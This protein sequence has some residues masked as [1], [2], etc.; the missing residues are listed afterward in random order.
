[1]LRGSSSVWLTT[2][3]RW[4]LSIVS[5]E[6][7]S[8]PL[9]LVASGQLV[10]DRYRVIERIG[11]G[12]LSVVYRGEDTRLPRDIC[13]KVL[14]RLRRRDESARVARATYEHFIQE[15]YALSRLTHPNTLRIFDF[16]YLEGSPEE[17]WGMPL[18][19]SEYMN[20]GTLGQL[21]GREGPLGLG[22]M[23]DI[24][25]GLAE[26]LI[27][28]HG[29]GI[30]HRDLKPPNILFGRVGRRR[31]AKLAD[32]GI[33]EVVSQL[34]VTS[35]EDARRLVM[36][37]LN[38][39]SPEQLRG[40]P[41]GPASDIY[42]LA[43]LVAFMLSGEQLFRAD[44][45]D[46]ALRQRDA[47][48]QRM[49]RLLER[50]EAPSDLVDLLVWSCSTKIQ[51]R[52]EDMET[53][54][55]RMRRA[56]GA[57]NFATFDRAEGAASGRARGAWN[58]D[59]ASEDIAS[60]PTAV[61]APRRE[62]LKQLSPAGGQDSLGGR[63]VVFLQAGEAWLDLD[64]GEARLRATLIPDAGP[65]P[66]LH[67]RGVNCFVQLDQRPPS[68]ATQVRMSSASPGASAPAGHAI[69]LI[70]PDQHVLASGMVCLGQEAGE[71]GGEGRWLLQIDQEDA[72]LVARDE[73]EWVALLDFGLASPLR[74]LYVPPARALS[75]APPARS[76]AAR[77]A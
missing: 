69:R 72:A 23:L 13:L 40:D 44:K 29:H 47:A 39:A 45:L 54:L 43:L 8:D 26:A 9:G 6:P 19:V 68:S 41:V 66:C 70:R 37:S 46:Q 32:F 57:A 58:E 74:L 64:L 73:C 77:S 16:G 34:R 20:G 25:G 33:A 15:A 18:Q 76:E 30:V 48:P 5:Q 12:G 17:A 4:A 21:V 27:E 50:T 60:F 65:G 35:R 51:E 24:V 67:L 28:A 42:S 56:S 2:E 36:Y 7:S 52:P 22:Q 1:M 62:L 55:E 38:W 11:A 63:K 61:M 75:A 49:R 53:F 31:L 59:L 14:Y 10:L 3:K 71:H